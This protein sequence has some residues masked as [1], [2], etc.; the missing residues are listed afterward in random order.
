MIKITDR[1][2]VGDA[3]DEEHL[4]LQVHDI[5]GIL[6][7]AHDMQA[8]RGWGCG[9]EY[10]QV[11]LVDGPGNTTAA[12]CAAVLALHAMLARHRRVMVCCHSESRSLSVA[13]FYINAVSSERKWSELTDILKEALD[14]EL[15]NINEAHQQAFKTI[16]WR[17]VNKLMRGQ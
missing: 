4:D 13:V 11:G 2:W 10:M 15:P 16:N 12:Y 6:N 9:V 5:G 1:I 14:R 8:T 7:V 17:S 3:L